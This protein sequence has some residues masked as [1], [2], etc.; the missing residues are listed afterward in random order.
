MVLN[1]CS[2]VKLK[3][4]A[5]SLY[6]AYGL[7]DASIHQSPKTEVTIIDYQQARNLLIFDS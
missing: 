2:A 5:K 4:V 1:E 6:S 3:T 7:L